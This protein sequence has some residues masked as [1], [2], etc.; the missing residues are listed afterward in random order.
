MAIEN[1]F[2]RALESK[3]MEL[4]VK[5]SDKGV[6]EIKFSGP[7]TGMF[8]GAALR[9]IKKGW[10]RRRAHFLR[11]QIKVRQDS[12]LEQKGKRDGGE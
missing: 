8:F 11:D 6:P 12:E 9:I 5:I 10:K 3:D 7:W 1:K 2:Q 4:L